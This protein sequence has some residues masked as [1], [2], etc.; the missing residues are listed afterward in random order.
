MPLGLLEQPAPQTMN[1]RPPLYFGRCDLETLLS[2]PNSVD[3][4]RLSEML[5][6]PVPADFT[7]IP[8]HKSNSYASTSEADTEAL[9]EG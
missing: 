6:G 8:K 5:L 4:I 3:W 1:Q 7:F 2:S 9:P